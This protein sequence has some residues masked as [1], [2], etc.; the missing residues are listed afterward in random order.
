VVI[1]QSNGQPRVLAEM[2]P[3]DYLGEMALR[4][5]QVRA[6]SAVVID[7]AS[8][9]KL[10]MAACERLMLASPAVKDRLVGVALRRPPSLYL[11]STLL[12]GA[13][14]ATLVELDRSAAWVRL[15]AG[16]TLFYQGDIPD[17]M[18]VVTHASI[19]VL[20]EE[21]GVRRVVRVLGRG[22][23]L[24]EIG[25]LLGTN[26]RSGRPHPTCTPSTCTSLTRD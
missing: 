22:A 11:A 20:I 25:V 10:P 18:Y 3:G 26:R 21:R 16:Q 5:R 8:L 4:S 13:T 2:R 12:G 15:A 19:E 7:S 14:N 6:A 9:L 23:F 24:G 1:D 17:A